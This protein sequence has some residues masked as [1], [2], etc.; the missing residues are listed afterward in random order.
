MNDIDDF[1]LN[2]IE[3]T[4]GRHNQLPVGQAAEFRWKRAHP[5]ESLK[6]CNGSQYLA[7]QSLSRL[8]FV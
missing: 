1:F 2:A 6:P 8:R 4:A 5:G 7:D 3:N